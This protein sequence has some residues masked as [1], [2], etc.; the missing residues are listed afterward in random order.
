MTIPMYIAE[1]APCQ[2]RGRLVTLNN[3]F[4]TGGQ[5]FASILDGVF[6]YDKKDGWRLVFFIN[7]ELLFSH[8]TAF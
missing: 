4:I 2:L 8:I 1:N 6:S 3:V 7:V 5:L